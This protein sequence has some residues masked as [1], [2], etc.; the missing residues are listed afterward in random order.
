M[1]HH[2]IKIS[3]HFFSHKNLLFG[4]NE[5]RIKTKFFGK[6][7]IGVSP[8]KLFEHMFSFN[9]GIFGHKLMLVKNKQIDF[10]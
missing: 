10:V 9:Q 6:I 3:K 1:F 2:G 5:N 4:K 7:R 8:L